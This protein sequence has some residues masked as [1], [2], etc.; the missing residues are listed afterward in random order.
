MLTTVL[1]L[2]TPSPFKTGCLLVLAAGLLYYSFGQEKPALLTSLDNRVND[3]MF[4]IRGEMTTTGKV[5]IIDIDEKSLRQVGQWP[6]PRN[7]VA[8][9]IRNINATN[10]KI[11]GLDIIFA[12]ADRTSP[13]KFIDELA[14]IL[15]LNI[16]AEEIKKLKANEALDHDITLGNALAETPSVLGYVFQTQRPGSSLLRRY[17]RRS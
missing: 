5:V 4:R 13:K 10:A 14:N 7:T 9:L 16:S 1:S 12:E 3:A 8:K 11:V 6:W 2:L 17:L 15:P